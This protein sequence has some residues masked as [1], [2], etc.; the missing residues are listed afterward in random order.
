MTPTQHLT[1][2][3]LAR[4]KP[5]NRLFIEGYDADCE[6]EYIDHTGGDAGL[7]R[8]ERRPG[9]GRVVARAFRLRPR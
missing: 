1:R 2:A 9:L 3:D 5:G 4:L 6:E 7:A 8:P